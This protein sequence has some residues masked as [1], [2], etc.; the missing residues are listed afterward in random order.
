MT[1]PRIVAAVCAV[2]SPAVA[3]QA[4]KGWQDELDGC[5]AFMEAGPGEVYETGRHGAFSGW[6]IAFPGGGVCNGSRTPCLDGGAAATFITPR[7][8]GA[9]DVTRTDARHEGA[10]TCAHTFHPG[11]SPSGPR[12][13][14]TG[15]WLAARGREGRMQ[16]RGDGTWQG[17]SDSGQVFEF[18]SD[19]TRD[20]AA[21]TFVLNP[22][23]GCAAG[24]V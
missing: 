16:D 21:F 22:D 19:F 24:V 7:S 15:E 13:A 20:E 14:Q 12:R 3:D 6:D 2:A 18:L 9:V 1:D 23:L 10:L 5:L 17:C 8:I 4:A 11:F